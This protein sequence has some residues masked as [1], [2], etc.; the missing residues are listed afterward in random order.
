MTSKP[1]LD[2]GAN[3]RLGEISGKI[4]LILVTMEAQRASDAQ[5][6]QKIETIQEEHAEHIAS[7]QKDRAWVLGGAAAVT[8]AIGSFF[9][10]LGLK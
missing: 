10:Y 9:A 6:F 8:G 5:R 3:Y 7:L 4:D 1:V 2:D